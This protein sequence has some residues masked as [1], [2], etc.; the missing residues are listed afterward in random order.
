MDDINTIWD[1]IETLRKLID[2]HNYRYYV[3][4]SPEISDDEYDRLLRE[5]KQLEQTYPQFVTP[6]SPTQRVGAAPV[7]AFGVVEHRADYP[8]LSLSNAFSTEELV[9]WYKRTLGLLGLKQLNLVAELKMD[10]L[11]VAL[12][13]EDGLLVKGSTRGDG[14]R[15]EDITSNLRTIRSIP[16][17]ISGDAPQRFEV[18]GEVYLSKAGF[19][20]LNEDRANAGQ[21]L[22]ANPRNAAAGSVRQL[23]PR[24]TSQRPL[25]IYVYGL[26]WAEGTLPPT[27]WETMEYLKSLGFKTNP[28]NARLTTIDQAERYYQRFL[29]EREHLPYEADGVVVKVDRFDIQAQLGAVGREPRWAIAYKFPAAQATTRLLDIRVNVGRTGTLNPY[30]VLEPV[31]VGGVVL[32]RAALHNEDDIKRKDIRIGDM[33]VVQ[34][35]GDVIPEVVAPVPSL[36]TN[37]EIFDLRKK[38][39]VCPSCGS[40]WIKP[41]DEAMA[42]CSNASCPAQVSERLKHF[43]SRGAMDIDGLGEKLIAV[44]L[45]NALIKDVSDLYSLNDKNNELIGLERMAQKSVSKLLRAVE[46]SKERPLSRVIFALGI[47]HVGS[48]T[49]D[50]LAK[51]YDSIDKLAHATEEELTAVPSI[52]PK[53]AESVVAF[54]KQDSNKRIIDKLRKAGVRLEEKIV[55][56]EEPTLSGKEFVITGK[57][58]S[59]PRSQAEARI[60]ELGGSV[61]SSVTKKTTFLVVGAEPGFKL[62]RAQQLGTEL[63]DEEA[64]LKLLELE[65]QSHKL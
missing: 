8:M 48:E 63:L 50:I 26:G 2:H 35:A 51:H 31:S 57:L 18:R 65:K 49:A 44:L 16:L 11:A 15:G 40:T 14:F 64:F 41:Q 33:V 5:L 34:R 54:F 6:Y 61:G 37:Q 59:F 29:K 45:A 22:F 58:E 1:K 13:Y 60:K 17:A 23:D 42:Y 56:S 39:P 62:D 28:E 55:T 4:D 30:A 20:K 12:T 3:L 36:R 47:R 43:V 25:D 46:A 32:K 24:I 7:E 53:I 10:G 21:P 52:G 27:H 38:Y 19:R 9:S